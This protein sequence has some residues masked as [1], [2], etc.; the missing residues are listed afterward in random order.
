[1][2]KSFLYG[3][4]MNSYERHKQAVAHS[5]YAH[6]STR[7]IFGKHVKSRLFKKWHH[8]YM[9]ER[10]RDIKRLGKQNKEKYRIYF[11]RTVYTYYYQE[12]CMN[13]VTYT[14]RPKC[15]NSH[16]LPINYASH[17]SILKRS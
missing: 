11:G 7:N 12:N 2:L 5:L 1:M 10:D 13:K 14:C 3:L 15:R 9:R 17:L 16:P 4:Y 8:R 6:L